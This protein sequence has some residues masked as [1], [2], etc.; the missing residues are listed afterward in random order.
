MTTI[1]RREIF[2][3]LKALLAN[4]SASFTI[5]KDSDMCYEL[6]S[7]KDIEWMGRKFNEMFFCSAVIQ[8]NFVGFYNM[9]VYIEPALLESVPE[10]LRKCLKGKS[11]FH[12][13]EW[14]PEMEKM[15][16]Q[17]VKD[18]LQFYKKAKFI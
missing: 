5:T 10:K 7:K 13:K 16:E 18:G 6:Y 14:N 3:G 12:L 1:N 17:T 9:A 11:C 4:H 2:E 8:S 15:V